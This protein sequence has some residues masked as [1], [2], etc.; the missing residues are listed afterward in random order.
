MHPPSWNRLAFSQGGEHRP[1]CAS[2]IMDKDGDREGGG[3]GRMMAGEND[4][5]IKE[6]KG[7]KEV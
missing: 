2:S 6:S 7:N 4:D 3:K 1:E 5:A